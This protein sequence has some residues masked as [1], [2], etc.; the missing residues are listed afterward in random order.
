MSSTKIHIPH[1]S[2]RYKWE[3]KHLQELLTD[4]QEAFLESYEPSHGRT[5]VSDY[6]PY[7]L[8]T[9]IT[10]P[11]EHGYKAI[12]DGQ[13]RLT[14]LTLVLIFFYRISKAKSELNI[15]TLE[16]CLRRNIYGQNE[17]NMNFDE[18]RRK[19]LDILLESSI[20]DENSVLYEQVESIP[21]IDP[22]TRRMLEIFCNI[23]NF[24][25]NEIKDRILPNFVDYL[26]E[27]VFL[28]EISVPTE[29]DG[30]KV[31]VTMND[32]GLK[33]SP[34][35][36]L[37]GFLLSK[38]KNN[39]NNKAAH[40][41]WNDC[42]R[43]LRELGSDED[44]AFF[45]TFLRSQYATTI[46]GKVKG[47]PPGDFENIGDSYYRWVIDNTST[48]GL[49]NEDNY[50][51]FLTINI[52]FFVDKYIKIKTAEIEYNH[53]FPHIFYNGARDF[54][55]QS[56]AILSS[57]ISTDIST[58]INKKFKITSYYLDY[59]LSIRSIN[60]KDNTYDNVRDLIFALIKKIRHKKFSQ[61]K[62]I[63]IKEIDSLDESIDSI[64]KI[65]YTNTKRQVL[66]QLLAR[67]AD[68]IE[69]HTDQTNKVG[70]AS[71][72]DRSRGTRTF[73]IEHII[74]NKGQEVL[75][76]YGDKNDF[77]SLKELEIERDNIGGL[78]LLPRG[79]NRSLKD[80]LYSDKVGKYATENILAQSLTSSLYDNNPQVGQF[81]TE[82]GINMT[83]IE[84]FNKESIDSRRKLYTEI[85]KKMWNKSE[86]E[87]L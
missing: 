25:V 76:S 82:E 67:I 10:T 37:K 30:H 69:D 9:I 59:V 8:G 60:L 62:E 43:S 58:E 4:I 22:G 53:A 42:V 29:Q 18:A 46:R 55:L 61:L 15:A 65:S 44:S 32:R 17:F 14:T 49:E 5:S 34:I 56:M 83:P 57:V 23:E 77:S 16:Q 72:V 47:D 78:I 85:A 73:D 70:F 36:L 38:I 13:Q 3:T 68:F 24:L 84:L 27:K 31:F 74:P 41:K 71:Y 45:K 26:I 80:L 66:L 7:F 40:T 64:G 48:L 63:I 50:F 81:I 28:F 75:N 19:L 54:T 35:D 51:D 87:R 52:P 86:I 79:R 21:H 39:D 33:L 2:T 6:A 12:V 20:D 11:A 1:L